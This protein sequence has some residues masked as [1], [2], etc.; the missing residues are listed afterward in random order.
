MPTRKRVQGFKGSR[1]QGLVQR[2]RR[3]LFLGDVC[4]EAGRK[5][6]R[7]ALPQLQEKTE[8]DFIIVNVENA[9]GGYGITPRLAEEILKSGVDCMTT[10]DHAFDRKEAWD[11]FVSQPKLLR[12]LNFPD[13]VPG[14]GQAVFEKN[15]FCIGVINL[16]G[17]AFMKPLD[18]PFQR[19]S[20][21]VEQLRR[22]TPVVIVDFHA[23]ATAEKQAMG[24]YLDG[25]VSAVLG[26]HTHVQTAD[27]RISPQGTAYISDVGMC[28]AFDSILGM[29]KDDSLRRILEMVP[30]RL[31]PATR[32]LRI[33]AVLLEIDESSG[34]ALSIERLNSV[35][36]E[37]PTEPDEAGSTAGR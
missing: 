17:R 19:V 24:W 34:R 5:A 15:G 31:H 21:V 3:V 11:C 30:V 9:A 12:P 35:A 6:V 16:M 28:G 20:Q 29:S 23:E 25:R 4:S 22:K 2:P 1:V 8:P 26:T 36:E 10:G 27:E 18:C 37:E 33:N 13:P 14:K 7:H 32:D